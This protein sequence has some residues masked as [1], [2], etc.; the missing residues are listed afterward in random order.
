MSTLRQRLVK[1][2]ER[3]RPPAINRHLFLSDVDEDGK[4]R[5]V[6]D[7]EAEAPNPQAPDHEPRTYEPGLSSWIELGPTD[8]ELLD[9]ARARARLGLGRPAPEPAPEAPADVAEPD[10]KPVPDTEVDEDE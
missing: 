4:L 5:Y 7:A 3:Q 8:R 2:E 6:P 9:Q 10:E 1:L